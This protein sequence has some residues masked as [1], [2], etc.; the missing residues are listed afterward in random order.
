MQWAVVNGDSGGRCGSERAIS[1]R[2]NDRAW[3]RGRRKSIEHDLIRFG[4]GRRI[5]SDVLSPLSSDTCCCSCRR[6]IKM[7]EWSVRQ[8]G[9]TQLPDALI[10]C[11]LKN[12]K[13]SRT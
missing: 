5:V 6:S 12:E 9:C 10:S 1:G 3:E 8:W 11:G 13:C 7:P 4:A 2:V